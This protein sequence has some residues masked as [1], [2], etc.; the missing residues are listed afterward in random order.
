MKT[1]LMPVKPWYREPW[2]WL[3]MSGPAIVVVAGLITI[4]LAVRT[5]DGLVVDDYYKRGLTVN[6]D[7]SRDLAA[8]TAG[9]H[10]KTTIDVANK[11]VTL[12]LVNAPAALNNL[13][14]TLSRASV[15]GHDQVITLQRTSRRDEKSVFVGALQPLEPGKWY[16][17]LDESSRSWRLITTVIVPDAGPI[18][19]FMGNAEAHAVVTP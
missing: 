4:V 2:P 11:R 5:H 16:A 10:A 19:F 17:T 12:G 1:Q 15:V 18:S 3:L 7:L 9:L 8:K 14:L 13:T 6:M